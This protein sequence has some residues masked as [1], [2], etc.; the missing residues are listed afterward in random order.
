MKP[1]N[2]SRARNAKMQKRKRNLKTPKPVQKN[3]QTCDQNFFCTDF[4][5]LTKLFIALNS[6]ALLPFFCR[7]LHGVE[8]LLFF[9]VSVTNKSCKKKLLQLHHFAANEDKL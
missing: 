5:F 1:R 7:L 2:L 6:I 9:A 3:N 4:A 8:F